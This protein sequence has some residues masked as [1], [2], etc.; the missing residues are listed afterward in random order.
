MLVCS[1]LHMQQQAALDCNM[2][3]NS[4]LQKQGK[5]QHDTSLLLKRLAES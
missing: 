1:G 2:L 5:E 4:T 3:L